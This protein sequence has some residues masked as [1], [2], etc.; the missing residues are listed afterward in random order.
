[1]IMCSSLGDAETVK[2]AAKA[3]CKH[4]LIKPVKKMD[5]L[6]K[7]TEALGQK[8]TYNNK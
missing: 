1:M 4:Y 5:L 8:P 7:V 6:E 2:R 3:G